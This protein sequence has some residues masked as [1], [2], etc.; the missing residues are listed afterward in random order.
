MQF[1][2]SSK[3][4]NTSNFIISD[5]KLYEQLLIAILDKNREKEHEGSQQLA[6][7]LADWLCAT[8]ALIKHE[9]TSSL[10]IAFK[11]GFYYARFLEKQNVEI[12]DDKAYEEITTDKRT[13]T[14][15]ILSSS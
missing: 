5:E 12:M 1:R 4:N 9:L 10:Y 8:G 15:N 14:E 3:K 11:L 2:V 13:T 7:I 6:K